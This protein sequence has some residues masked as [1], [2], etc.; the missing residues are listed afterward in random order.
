MREPAAVAA[1]AKIDWSKVA[2][3]KIS[4]GLSRRVV[5]TDSFTLVYYTYPP[6]ATFK[7]H[8]HPEAQLTYV[9]R[10]KIAFELKGEKTTLVA[11]DWLYVPGGVPHSAR[12]GTAGPVV[13]I[14]IFSPRRTDFPDAQ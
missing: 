9:I 13:A 3:E 2:E 14:N 8:K 12:A 1:A 10:G 5:Q 6:G 7:L 11:G 4:G